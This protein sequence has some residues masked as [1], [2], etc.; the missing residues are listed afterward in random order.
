[1]N[2]LKSWNQFWFESFAPRNWY[3]LRFFMCSLMVGTYIA[4]HLYLEEFFSLTRGLPISDPSGFASMSYRW[5]VLQWLSSEAAISGLH[6]AFVVMLAL[7]ALGVWARVLSVLVFVLHV[8]FVHANIG[9]VYGVDLLF[10][11]FLF[12]FCIGH[13]RAKKNTPGSWL[14]SVAFRL[15]Q[16]QLCIVYA[17]S[18]LEKLKGVT[19]WKGE[20][21]WNV[22]ANP[23]LSRFDFT[24]VSQFPIL[25]VISVYLT[26]FWEIYFPVLVWTPKMRRVTLLFGVGFHLSIA[27]L[28]NLFWFGMFMVT[29]YFLFLKAEEI[30]WFESKLR[31]LLGDRFFQK[32]FVTHR[33]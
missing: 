9:A 5:S 4:R 29:T 23:Q 1:M 28:M 33:A 12:Y 20:S 10:I 19:W 32:I 13:E 30:Q 7:L 18:G 6:C 22:L 25:L 14:S 17:Y 15:A 2:A 31:S 16:I 8:S 3:W 11:F 26:L 24:W 27:L 21:L